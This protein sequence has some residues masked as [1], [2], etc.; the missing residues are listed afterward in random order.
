[1]KIIKK[2]VM[3]VQEVEQVVC[4]KCG[5]TIEVNK[6]GELVDYLAINK[7]WGYLSDFDGEEHSIDLCQKCY[8]QLTKEFKITNFDKL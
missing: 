3:E 5:N 4:N 8:K 6:D 2:V 1:M 7:K